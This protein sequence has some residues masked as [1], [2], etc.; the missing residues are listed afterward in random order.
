[1]YLENY[2]LHNRPYFDF[3]WDQFP[4]NSILEWQYAD[5]AS[6]VFI[7]ESPQWLATYPEYIKR[8]PQFFYPAD[9]SA[10]GASLVGYNQFYLKFPKVRHFQGS[11]SGLMLFACLSEFN[12]PTSVMLERLKFSLQEAK[13]ENLPVTFVFYFFHYLHSHNLFQALDSLLEVIRNSGVEV[14]LLSYLDLYKNSMHYLKD[15]LFADLTEGLAFHTL[16]LQ[17]E[18]FAEGT[19]AFSFLPE[20]KVDLQDFALEKK[21][22]SGVELFVKRSV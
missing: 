11:Y 6:D 9:F 1:M 19:T 10:G 17:L 14:R 15:S 22:P 7:M 8:L 5:P 18:S 12:L 3:Q 4:L 16:P 2:R 13:K 21:W 20:Q